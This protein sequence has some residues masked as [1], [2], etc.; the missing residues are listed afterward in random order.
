MAE[1]EIAPNE[2]NAPAPVLPKAPEPK[3]DDPKEKTP[4]PKAPE[5]KKEEPKKVVVLPPTA[6]PPPTPPPPMQP[7][8]RIA[9][10][11]HVKPDQEDNPNAKFI[12]DDAN[13]VDKETVATQTSHDQDDKNP[14]PGGNHAGPK[15]REGDSQKTKI[16]DS[17]DTPGEKNKAPG[18]KG[19]EFDVQPR[20]EARAQGGR[21]R[22]EASGCVGCARRGTANLFRARLPHKNRAP[23]RPAAPRRPRPRSPRAKKGGRSTPRARVARGP[24]IKAEWARRT[25]PR[26]RA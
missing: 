23:T 11:Q 4:D 22:A 2:P 18:D 12:G 25:S 7:D 20:A 3:K 9:V 19:T 13:K 6:T 8:K 26:P 24:E 14:T 15:D 1:N 21:A 17:E 5:E 10:K 16:A